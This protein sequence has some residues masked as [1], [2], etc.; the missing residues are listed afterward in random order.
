MVNTMS[1]EN[2]IGAVF[3]GDV[4]DERFKVP[5]DYKGAL[6][7]LVYDLNKMAVDP[8][9][10]DPRTRV[11]YQKSFGVG[12]LQLE[13]MLLSSLDEDYKVFLKENRS[14]GS[15]L[16]TSFEKIGELVLLATR[17]GFFPSP[18]FVLQA[19]DDESVD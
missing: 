17:C 1:D 14:K 5:V 9:L 19:G 4:T 10:V 6:I 2:S 3:D 7:R 13:K 11:V 18:M 8:R 15:S 16:A 12:V